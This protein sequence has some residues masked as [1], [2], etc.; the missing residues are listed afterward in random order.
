MTDS[1]RSRLLWKKFLLLKRSEGAQLLEFALSLPIL[2]VVMIGI[3]DFGQA[4]NTKQEL[5]NSVREGLRIGSEAPTADLTQS[6]CSSP[7][8]SSPCSVQAIADAVKQYMVNTGLNASCLTPNSPSSSSGFSWTYTCGNGT[9][10]TINRGYTFTDSN[11]KTV[12]GTRVSL[13]YPYTWTLNRIIGLLA[14]STLS[15]PSTLTSS[16]VMQNFG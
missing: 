15:L 12:V 10:M 7:S 4:W 16:G 3:F 2:L 11:G 5:A 8:A 6:S 9:S 14:G 1:T 13:T